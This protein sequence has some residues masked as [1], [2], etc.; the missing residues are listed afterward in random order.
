[1]HRPTARL[2]TLLELLQARKMTGAELARRLEVDRRTVRRYVETLREMGIPVEGGRGRYGAYSLKRGYK[3]PPLMFTDEE[4]LGLSL[5]LVAARGLG[6]SGVAP[7]VEGALAK[8]ERVMP[9]AWR[10]RL[11]ALEHT[12]A[13]TAAM[14]ATPPDGEVVSALAGATDERRR[15]RLRYRSARGE[16]TIRVV[17][18]YAV[19]RTEGRWHLFGHCHLRSDAR[20]FRLDRMLEAEVLE[21]GYER[22]PDLDAPEAVLRAV[23]NGPWEFEV[24]LETSVEGA[25]EQVPPVVASAEEAEGGVLMRGTADDLDWTARLLAGLSC[26]FTV[27]KPPELREALGRHAAELAR[28][29]G[30]AGGSVP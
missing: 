25:R 15:V 10:G 16:E 22:P 4:A 26:P 9:E 24:L 3:M 19:L 7:A 23:T 29:A 2:L 30:R 17:D 5:G 13:L 12:V 18:P 1:V 6:I 14:P 11:R 20:L 28:L 8:V 21:E 27:R